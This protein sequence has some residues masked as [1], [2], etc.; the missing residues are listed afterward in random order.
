MI[1]KKAY[2][3]EDLIGFTPYQAD[4]LTGVIK[5]DANENPYAMDH[6]VREKIMNW[7]SE[8]ESFSVYPDSNCLDLRK[9]IAHYYQVEDNQVVCGVGSDQ[10]ID[11]MVRGILMP[12]DAV[13]YP[14]PSF[15]MYQSVISLNHGKGIPVPLNRDFSYNIEAMI[16][17]CHDHDAKILILC[18]PNNPTGNSLSIDEIRQIAQAV[19]CPIMVDE[20]YGEFT[21]ESAISLINEFE[22][23]VVLRTFSKAYGLAGL[24]I[25][26]GIGSQKVLYPI[27]IS[28]PPYNINTFTQ[29]VAQTVIENSAPYKTH[30][31][32]MKTQRE[33]IKEALEEMAIK[34][35]PSDAN[36]LLIECDKIELDEYLKTKNIY[37]RAMQIRGKKMYRISVGTKEQNQLVLEGIK[38]A[39]N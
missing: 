36:F 10:L 34:V 31:E 20:A 37:I 7:L 9:S 22:N 14:D 24:R 35:Y 4:H 5:L 19:T 8:N 25:G 2:I 13:I 39:I 38:E 27:E 18:T 23:I 6:L 32:D 26:Y 15:S 29:M 17:A 21:N 3:R 1:N 11:C 33:K 30:I 16:Q 28:K 12:G